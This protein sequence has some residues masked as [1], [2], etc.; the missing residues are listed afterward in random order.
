MAI[1]VGTRKRMPDIKWVLEQSLTKTLA[2][3]H[4]CSVAEI[5]RRYRVEILGLKALRV[6]VERPEKEPLI[7]TF[8]GI[9]LTRIPE[10]MGITDFDPKAAWLWHVPR[11]SPD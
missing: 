2:C 1:N 5:Y 9:P 10:G 8:G 7:A 4:R 3:K 11:S 6:V